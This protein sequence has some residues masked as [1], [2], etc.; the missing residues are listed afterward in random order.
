MVSLQFYNVVGTVGAALFT[1]CYFLI[2]TGKMTTDN[3]WYSILNMIGAILLLFSLYYEFN[4]PSV[5]IES[6]WLL[7]SSYGVLRCVS[8]KSKTR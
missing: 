6:F 4:L 8:H 7:I 2:Q 5:F 1:I 3:I